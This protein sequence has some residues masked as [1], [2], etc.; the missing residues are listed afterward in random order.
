MLE[1][2]KAYALAAVKWVYD[3]ITV[4]VA[5]L[6]GVA[7]FILPLLNLIDGINIA[8]LVGA[9]TAIKIVTGVAVAKAIFAFIA[10]YRKA[11]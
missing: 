1:K 3:W 8:P 9:D 5:G 10:S 4:I 11:P 2:V 6:A 7:T